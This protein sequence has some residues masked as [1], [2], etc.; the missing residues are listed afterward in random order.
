MLKGSGSICSYPNGDTYFNTRVNPGLSS[1]GTG[2][3]LSGMMAALIAQ[4]LEPENALLLAVYLHGA[5]ADALL[6]TLYGPVGMTATEIIDSA[7]C[8]INQ[9]I[10]GVDASSSY[11]RLSE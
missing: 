5:A 4:N 6:K 8:L 9:W 10:Y 2:D 11:L 3:I 7:R 1:A